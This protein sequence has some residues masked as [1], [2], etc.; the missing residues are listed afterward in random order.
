M[1]L[2]PSR[3]AAL[4]ALEAALPVS[5]K[6]GQD[7]QAALNSH[8]P[9]L[10][11][12]RDKALATELCYGYAR[13]KGR[14][15]HLARL[16]LQKP[17]KTHPYVLRVLGLAAY[18]LT[19]LDSIPAHA[20][21]SWAVEAVKERLGQAQAGVANAVLRRIQELGARANDRALYRDTSKDP[22]LTLSAWHSCPEWIVRMWLDEY[23]AKTAEA[24]LEAQSAPPLTGVRVNK[25]KQGARELFDELAA[26]FA[27]VWSGYP[28]LGFDQSS[29]PSLSEIEAL[30]KEGRLTRQSPAVGDIMR[31]LGAAD[32]LRPVWD[33]CAGRGGKTTALLEMACAA[34]K[35]SEGAAVWASDVNMR[36]LRGLRG[37]ASRL[38]LP[39]PELF[40]AGGA[41]PPLKARPATILLDAPCSGLGVLA[42]R[43]DAK[44]KR[45]PGDVST[46]AAIQSGLLR[47][48]AEVLPRG[49][50]LVY[51]TCTMTL[52]E[53]EAQ[54]AL[55]ESLGFVR[56]AVTNPDAGSSLR[57]CFWGGRFVKR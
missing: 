51:M 26:R 31:R 40:L 7:L 25:G 27:P 10:G 15:E 54:A 28:W 12:P 16:Y 37:E 35:G 33:A 8:L 55:I 47:A 22:A 45:S 46:L 4:A 5:G 30:E 14:M 17:N 11:D 20:T 23:G 53:N 36:R 21:L 9:R 29:A 38:G 32:W 19:G 49:G 50:G 13:L 41:N 43:P 1:N 34:G 39:L 3:G 56:K 44:W 42:R 52:A 6:P 48:C 24:M 57:E 2:P 18:E